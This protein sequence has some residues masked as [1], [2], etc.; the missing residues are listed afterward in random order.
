MMSLGF[1]SIRDD[2]TYARRSDLARPSQRSKMP[3]TYRRQITVDMNSVENKEYSQ[4]YLQVTKRILI[5]VHAKLLYTS[6]KQISTSG[7]NT[8]AGG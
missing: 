7:Q 4:K 3:L 5:N 6:M 1:V 2:T 8:F